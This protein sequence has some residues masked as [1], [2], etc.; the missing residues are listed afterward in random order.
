[1]NQQDISNTNTNRNQ[2]HMYHMETL[3]VDGKTYPVVSVIP[4]AGRGCIPETAEDKIH[5]LI[6]GK[7]K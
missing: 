4:I 2:R 7:K 5:Y 6:S 3:V 1:M